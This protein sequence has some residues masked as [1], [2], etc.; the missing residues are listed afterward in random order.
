MVVA[1]CRS[2]LGPGVQVFGDGRDGGREAAFDGTISWSATCLDSVEEDDRWHGYTVLQSKFMQKPKP[3]PLDNAKWLQGQ[4]R[5]EIAGWAE[6][7]DEGKRTRL[8]DY[9]IFVTNIDLSPVAKT[10]G[11]D[12]VEKY[13]R[14]LL[15]QGSDAHDAGLRVRGFR[16]WHA[17]QIRT[18]LDAHQDI[19][20]AFGGLLTVGDVVAALVA[21]RPELG[22]LGLDDPLRAEMVSAIAADRWIRLGQSGGS[23]DDKLRID[24]VVVD[25]PALVSGDSG[26]S[27]VRAVQ[28][29][30]TR[31]DAVL[32]PRQADRTGPLGVV[33]V[34][35]PGHGKTT[36]SQLIAQAYRA[37][38]LE[39]V[40]LAPGARS[41][42]EA[43]AAALGR[44][45]MALPGNRRWPVRV[46]LAKYAEHLSTG[47]DTALLRWISSRVSDRAA[48]EVQPAQLTTWM[49][50]CPWAVILDGLDEVPSLDARRDLYDRIEEFV[51]QAEDQDADLLVVVTTRP[52]GYEE[53]LPEQ[54]FEHLDLQPLPAPEAAEFASRLTAK[55]FE[56]DAEMHAEVTARMAAAA[57]DPTTQRLMGTPLQVTVMSMI[58]E[59]YP[60]LPPDRFTL[61]Q[62]YYETIYD[63]EVA[64]RIVVS[65]LLADHRQDINAIHERVGVLLQVE[66][67]RAEHAEAVLPSDDFR[68]LAVSW[69]QGRG[70]EPA[71]AEETANK[72]VQAALHRLVLLVPREAGLGFEIRT[73]QEL[74]AAR[75]VTEGTDEQVLGR[76]HLM[77]DSAHWRNTWLL[78]AG[79]LLVSSGRFEPLL[80]FML[81]GLGNDPES[82]GRRLSAGPALASALIQDNLADRRPSFERSLVQIAVSVVNYPP[83]GELRSIAAALVRLLDGQYRAIVLERVSAAGTA[84]PAR[85]AA[86]AAVID[87]MRAVALTDGH[88]QTLRLVRERLQLSSA[89][90]KAL[91]PFRLN[92]RGPVP[93]GGEERL[94]PTVLAAVQGLGLD[95]ARWRRLS[96]GLTVLAGWH[97]SVTDTEP[98]L[99]VLRSN[100]GADPYALLDVV[101][102]P[103]LAVA[104]DLALGTLPEG[105]WGIPAVVAGLIQTA[106]SRR[107]IGQQIMTAVGVEVP[108]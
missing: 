81:R 45:R 31:G 8:P 61:F 52:T 85:R 16:I 28:H 36:L 40:N 35:G 69:M 13:V 86:A 29:V 67:E 62:L 82:L 10:G 33:L 25:V 68:A 46:D 53:R 59:K 17:D 107:S 78:A 100:A 90:E 4:I 54:W 73:L 75:A 83:V 39:P 7:A 50:I 42:V 57:T 97:F 11:I 51:V 9:L 5:K 27:Q 2:E 95:E 99:A 102:D 56:D 22:K 104:L 55:R 18:M 98:P 3:E 70:Y 48:A 92:S 105:H 64:K 74:M 14:E 34:G 32:R 106:R 108:R 21:Q 103:E 19:R 71:K 58:V 84:G 89:E 72:L 80:S 49:R 20:Y 38:M 12:T 41:T 76:L 63:R 15:G 91:S 96:E 93:N 24:D 88:R 66:S 94:V 47:A 30:L 60:T 43:T 37:A 1:L 26:A 6:A 87:A 44:L 101:A 79:R 77:A 23:G 65:R